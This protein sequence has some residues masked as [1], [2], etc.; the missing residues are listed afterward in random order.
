[1]TSIAVVG[2]GIYGCCAALKLSNH[3]ENVTLFDP[4]GVLR[5]ASAIN[6]FR[7]HAGYH[8]PRSAET[9]TKVLK[10]RVE[11]LETFAEACV[12]GTRNYYAIPHV[13]SLTSPSRY[14][15]VLREHGLPFEIEHPDWMNFDFID[16]CYRV[17]ESVY[18]PGRLRKLLVERI[19]ASRITFKKLAF[20][21]EEENDFDFVIYAT[22][23]GSGSYKKIF[24]RARRQ[25]AEKVLC[26]VPAELR[27]TTLVVI[28]GPFTA[29]DC[30]GGSDMAQFGSAR[31]TNH[32]TTVDP[33]VDIPEFYLEHL[34]KR[35]F[36]KVDFT[37]FEAMRRHA[38]D[39]VPAMKEATYEG[40]KFT[41]R[42]VED[43]SKTDRRVLKIEEI[44]GRI[45]HVFSGKVVSAVRAARELEERISG[46][47]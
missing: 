13:G 38:C 20:R 3:F 7:I 43:D 2:A 11:F 21:T 29:F 27:H 25:V 42:M 40:S 47:V 44:D 16:R 17:D 41:V 46:A 8:Y 4:L 33:D 1:M 24:Q 39:A 45:F 10:D 32:W 34:D 30:Y 22:Y 15:E 23:G 35:D 31:H 5:A 6:Q 28:D 36:V 12:E 9:I 18:D 37:N 19:E 14:E 26:R